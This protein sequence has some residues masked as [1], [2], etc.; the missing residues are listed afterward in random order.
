VVLGSAH[1]SEAAHSNPRSVQYMRA[2]K[3]QIL[4]SSVQFV[5]HH[6]SGSDF[7]R[8]ASKSFSSSIGIRR[9]STNF[10]ASLSQA[11]LTDVLHLA[12]HRLKMSAV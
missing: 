7:K 8:I 4:I 9:S 2:R 10:A 11:F 12:V 5:G 1:G 3:K 6:G